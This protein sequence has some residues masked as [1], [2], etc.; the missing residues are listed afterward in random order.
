MRA[1]PQIRT[2]APT[3]MLGYG[4]TEEAF[5][6]GLDMGL[7]FIGCDAGSMDPGPHY[8]GEGVPFVSRQALKRDLGLLLAGAVEKGIPLLIGSAGGGGGDP[9]LDLVADIAREVARERNLHFPMALIHAEPGKDYLKRARAQ[10]RIEPLGPI[11]ELDD[12]TIDDSTRIVAMMG[13]EPFQ[14]AL[15]DGAQV[16]IAGRATD[17]S[18]YSAI[19]LMRGCQPGLVWHLAKIIECG[20]QVVTPRT[21][22]D[23]VIGTIDGDH[24]TVEPAHPDK[25]CT[26]M[27]VAA[28]T[29]YENPSPY[30]LEEPDGTLVTTHAA[31]EQIDPRIVRVSGSR[32]EPS[33]RYTVK[34]EGV[35]SSGYRTVFVAGVRDPQ[36][37]S[38]IDQFIASCH[39]R[40]AGEART[41]GIGPDD[42]RLNVRVYGRDATMG[43][44]EPQRN[45][46][47]HEIGIVADVLA[48]DADSSKAVLA[49]ARYALLHT[50]FPGRKC[51]S[52]N[53]AIPFSPSDMFVGQTYEFSVWH[54][55]AIDDP[56]EPFRI[57]MEEV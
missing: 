17:A 27:R 50:D 32:F 38:V 10:G 7:D 47:P 54:R 14:K 51:I 30:H 25:R 29:L 44:R 37:I 28:H 31:Y 11:G 26:R 49:K 53:L 45:A 21:G 9:Q 42:Y 6:R 35:K 1:M 36:L 4:F 40:V 24:F 20:G 2:M 52:G 48:K 12:A 34:L 18:I 57:E 43:P 8:L 22:Q 15:A 3:G 56:L 5:R 55:M 39:E 46:L 19:P 41:L 23:C 33:R 16:V 13:V